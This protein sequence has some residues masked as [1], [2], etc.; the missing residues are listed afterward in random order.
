MRK[1][2]ILGAAGRDFHN[3]NVFFRDH[4]GYD[5]EILYFGEAR[6]KF[7]H[8]ETGYPLQGKHAATPCSKC[9]WRARPC[10]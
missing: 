7:A 1:V 8:A 3:F 9:L 4:P 2:V 6:E 5:F 10:N